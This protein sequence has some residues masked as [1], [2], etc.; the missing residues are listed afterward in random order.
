M[1]LLAGRP[2]SRMD[3]L[4]P[5]QVVGLVPTALVI[6]GSGVTATVVVAV[7]EGQPLIVAIR[8]YVPAADDVTFNKEGF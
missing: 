7:A 8:L 1:V 5:P 2:E 6:T 4:D 3:P